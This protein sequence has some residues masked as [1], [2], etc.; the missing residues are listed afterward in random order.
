[1]EY[2][3]NTLCNDAVTVQQRTISLF[4]NDWSKCQY[5]NTIRELCAR[6]NIRMKEYERIVD[7]LEQLS[8]KSNFIVEAE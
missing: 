3:F 2:T 6:Q 7:E 5:E 4:S 1:M 8:W